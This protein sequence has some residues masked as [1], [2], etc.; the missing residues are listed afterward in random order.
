MGGLLL[1]HSVVFSTAGTSAGAA[2]DDGTG[3]LA[4]GSVLDGPAS[5]M[6]GRLREQWS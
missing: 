1:G 6:L 5:D 3:G 2:A 4:G